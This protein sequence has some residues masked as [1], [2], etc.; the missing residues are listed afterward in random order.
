M[1][2]KEDQS[3]QTDGSAQFVV[4]HTLHS[5]GLSIR[6]ISRILGLNRRTVSRRLK[7]ENLKPYPKRTYPSKLDDYKDYIRTRINQAHPDRIPSTVILKE[8]KDM[9]YTGSLRILQKYTKTIYDSI[10][11][12]R[13]GKKEEIIRFETDKG[14]QAQVDWTTIRSGKK[15]IYAFVMVLG[16]SRMAF[17]YFTDNMRQDTFQSCFC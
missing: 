15:P 8:I 6:Q 9:G 3:R 13:D 5:Q 14:F 7:E 17:V 11:L 16:Y 1:V 2:S 4:I 10:G 12:K